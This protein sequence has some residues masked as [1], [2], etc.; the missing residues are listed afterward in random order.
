MGLDCHRYRDS[1]AAFKVIVECLFST[2][3]FEH[4]HR[5]VDLMESKSATRPEWIDS[6]VARK[7][8]RLSD[9]ELMHLR[10][11]GKLRFQKQGNAFLYSSHDVERRRKA[12]LG[13]TETRPGDS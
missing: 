12:A 5:K 13:D 9:C 7:L 2:G 1:L 8:L 10:E 3:R 6:Q 4:Q 11:S